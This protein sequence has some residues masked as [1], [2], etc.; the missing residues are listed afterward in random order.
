L[1]EGREA[2]GF[3]TGADAVAFAF[4]E[5]AVVGAGGER[6]AVGDF[7][8]YTSGVEECDAPA[9]SA[10][11]FPAAV[12]VRVAGIGGDWMT[13]DG[14]NDGGGGDINCG[15]VPFSSVGSVLMSMVG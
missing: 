8:E 6:S 13:S 1:A 11:M 15:K 10:R 3:L 9:M 7:T 4:V 14:D 5:G 2:S 12:A